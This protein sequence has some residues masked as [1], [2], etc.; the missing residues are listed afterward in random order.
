MPYVTKYSLLLESLLLNI[1]PCNIYPDMNAFHSEIQKISMYI[2]AAK[3][4]IVRKRKRRTHAYET[5][6]THAIII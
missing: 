3:N 4:E 5:D 6:K 2:H 1:Q